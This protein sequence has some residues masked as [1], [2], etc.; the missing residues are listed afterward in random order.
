MQLAARIELFPT[1]KLSLKTKQRRKTKLLVRPFAG[2]D[3]VKIQTTARY[4][5]CIQDFN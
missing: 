4:Q 1:I 2:M 5:K 3:D